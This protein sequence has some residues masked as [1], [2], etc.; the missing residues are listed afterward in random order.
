MKTQMGWTAF[1]VALSTLSTVSVDA[2]SIPLN[3]SKSAIEGRIARINSALK[4][5][6]GNV[7]APLD[8]LAVWGNGAGGRGFANARGGGGWVNAAGGGGFANA[9]PWRNGWADG[10]GFV[11]TRGGSFVNR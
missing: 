3:S 9:N 10:G 1:L 11:N 7:D 6:T 4:T 5:Q 8:L 2:A